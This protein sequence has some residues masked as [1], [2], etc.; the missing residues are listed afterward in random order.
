MG[1]HCLG[2]WLSNCPCVSL[3]FLPRLCRGIFVSVNS[4]S[5][6]LN[7]GRNYYEGLALYEVYGQDALL[8]RVFRQGHSTYRAGRLLEAMRELKNFAQRETP[9]APAKKEVLVTEIEMPES[10]VEET[11]DTY[12]AEWLPLYIEMNSLRHMLLQAPDDKER[13]VMAHKVLALERQCERIWSRRDYMIKN[14]TELKEEAPASDVVT[15]KN[16][17]F[18]SIVNTRSNIAK[19]RKAIDSAKTPIKKTE[20]KERLARHT[21]RLGELTKMMKHG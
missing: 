20:A 9:A 4:I 5:E 12:R 1:D 18:K 11:K 13:G 8:L 6:W 3:S 10:A 15:D 14:G 17:V 21:A 19:A 2:E 16:L 7:S